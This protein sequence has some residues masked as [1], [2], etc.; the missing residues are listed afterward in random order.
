[1]SIPDLPWQY[2]MIMVTLGILRAAR[3]EVTAGPPAEQ[4]YAQHS[5]SSPPGMCFKPC[6][7][8]TDKMTMCSSSSL[9]AF[10]S[11]LAAESIPRKDTKTA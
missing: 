1:M 11:V 9:A 5:V 10:V 4:R 2:Q 3:T 8:A 6:E 7:H